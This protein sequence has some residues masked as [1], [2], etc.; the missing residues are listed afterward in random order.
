MSQAFAA[1]QE[2]SKAAPVK[3]EPSSYHGRWLGIR[4]LGQVGR[5]QSIVLAVA[6]KQFRGRTTADALREAFPEMSVEQ[7]KAAAPILEQ[8]IVS[9]RLGR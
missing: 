8:L 9:E 4:R 6:S 3:S 5:K 2:R 7:L 1:A